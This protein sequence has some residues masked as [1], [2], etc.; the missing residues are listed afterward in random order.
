M[1]AR[2]RGSAWESA[3]AEYLTERG[4]QI[5]ARNY[6]RG[7]GEVD[8]IAAMEGATV[9]VEVKQRATGRYGTSGEA[10]TRAKQARI[11][12]AALYYLKEHHLL[13]A[14]VR[15][16]VV[17]IDGAQIRHLKSAFPFV[18]RGPHY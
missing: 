12:E 17:E 14:R 8:L 9:F 18:S 15:F 5:L 13:D 4:A 6:R 11:C 1:S 10:V 7:A 16:D 3:A 2:G